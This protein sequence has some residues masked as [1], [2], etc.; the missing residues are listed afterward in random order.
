GSVDLYSPVN[1]SQYVDPIT[2]KIALT[3]TEDP[4]IGTVLHNE[5]FTLKPVSFLSVYGPLVFIAIWLVATIVI[6]IKTIVLLIFKLRKKQIK[7]SLWSHL[8][9]LLQLL[10]LG[11]FIRGFVGLMMVDL[12]ADNRL[13][14]GLI[15]YGTVLYL[16]LSVASVLWFLIKREKNS[17]YY[18]SLVYSFMNLTIG[19]YLTIM[20]VTGFHFF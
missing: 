2:G 16:L 7:G 14:S 13:T 20:G 9:P 6:I 18:Q 12:L 15:A 19:V 17:N 4:L 1:Q 11:L 10:S 3:V 8:L 5:W